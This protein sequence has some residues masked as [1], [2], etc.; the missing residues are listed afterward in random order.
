MLP[1]ILLLLLWVEVVVV[2]EVGVV[3]VAECEF[4]MSEATVAATE[5]PTRHGSDPGCGPGAGG[6]VCDL[7]RCCPLFQREFGLGLPYPLDTSSLRLWA[8]RFRCDRAL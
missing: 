7:N 8:C 6:S 2:A 5:A 1:F 3:G 4:V